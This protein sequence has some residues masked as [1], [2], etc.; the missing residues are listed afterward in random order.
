[1]A[2]YEMYICLRKAT[3]E[4]SVPMEIQDKVGWNDYEYDDYGNVTSTT[5][6]LPTWK[7]ATFKGM[8]GAPKIS[9]SGSFIIVKGEFSMK[10]GELSAIAALGASMAYPNNSILTKS[11]AQALVASDSWT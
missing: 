11:E 5:A 7:Q 6:V 10:E 9:P 4:A 3:Y 2:H 1:M 8:L